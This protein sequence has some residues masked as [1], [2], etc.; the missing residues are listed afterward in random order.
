MAVDE[1]DPTVNQMLGQLLSRHGVP[2]RIEDG[3][4][5]VMPNGMAMFANLV[6]TRQEP[7]GWTSQLNV[8]LE[9]SRDRRIIECFAHTADRERELP[10]DLIGYFARADFHAM[11]A[12]LQDP[13]AQADPCGDDQVEAET[14]MIG[15]KSRRLTIG[16]ITPK[17][18]VG[19]EIGGIEFSNMF[20]STEAFI[21]TLPMDDRC[22]WIRVYIAQVRG[23]LAIVEFLL[24]NDPVASFAEYAQHMEYVKTAGFYS[25]RNFMVIHPMDGGDLRVQDR[26]GEEV[27]WAKGGAMSAAAPKSQRPLTKAPWWRFW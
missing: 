20:R 7:R 13:G 19:D 12:L 26:T 18:T 4:R 11:L 21:K 5:H 23:E 25:Y 1:A 16:S 3:F 22:H 17:Q 6:N 8:V 10:G 27:S 24:D 15:G 2:F 14:W 9:L